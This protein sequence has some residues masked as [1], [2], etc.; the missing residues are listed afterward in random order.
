MKT[1]N[2][3]AIE[4]ED[5]YIVKG[6]LVNV[7]PDMEYLYPN[8]TSQ[9]IASSHWNNI[10]ASGYSNMI[11]QD[12]SED[13]IT[14]K[15]YNEICIPISKIKKIEKV[16]QMS[17]KTPA[18]EIIVHKNEDFEDCPGIYT[19]L[20]PDGY[21]TPIDLVSIESPV[22]DVKKNISIYSYTDPFSEE[23]QRKDTINRED[24]EEALDE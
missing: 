19:E 7:Y 23:W 16:T 5:G 9:K 18:G 22:G 15:K 2:I 24:I 20:I 21:D 10:Q 6:D 13:K 8:Q 3:H 17:V 1:T 12:I 4:T 11:V 14:L